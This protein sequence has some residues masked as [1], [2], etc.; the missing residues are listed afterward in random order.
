MLNIYQLEQRI[1]HV[2]EAQ[3]VVGMALV[4]IQNAEVIYARGFGVTSSE[5]GGVPVTPHTLFCIGSISKKH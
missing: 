5:D 1:Q 2:T 3:R 4:M